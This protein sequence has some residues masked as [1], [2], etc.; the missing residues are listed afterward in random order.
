MNEVHLSNTVRPRTMELFAQLGR[1]SIT[2]HLIIVQRLMD[3]GNTMHS[4][5]V[6]LSAVE[7]GR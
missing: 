5:S 2:L 3:I 1:N 6:L 7:M 4:L